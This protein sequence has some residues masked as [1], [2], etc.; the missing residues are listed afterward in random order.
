[1]NGLPLLSLLIAIPLLAGVLCLMVKAEGARWITLIG[2][3]IDLA[4]SVYLWVRYD[5]DGAHFCP[6]SEDPKTPAAT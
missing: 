5:P 6:L 2:T 4:L 3:L 1:M